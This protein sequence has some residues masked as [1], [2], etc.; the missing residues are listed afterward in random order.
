MEEINNSNPEE[1]S[2]PITTDYSIEARQKKQKA[3]IDL[4][5][6]GTYWK[7]AWHEPEKNATGIWDYYHIKRLEQHEGFSSLEGERIQFDETCLYHMDDRATLYESSFDKT[8]GGYY[9][10]Q[11]TKEE[12]ERMRQRVIDIYENKRR[13][14]YNRSALF[15]LFNN[16]KTRS[17]SYTEIMELTK[18][19]HEQVK[20][21]IED[22]TLALK[23]AETKEQIE[24]IQSIIERIKQNNMLKVFSMSEKNQYPNL[25]FHFDIHVIDTSSVS[26]K[27][28]YYN[29]NGV[30][31]VDGSPF[32][33]NGETFWYKVKVCC[34]SLYAENYNRHHYETD[35]RTYFDDGN[36]NWRNDDPEGWRD[37]MA[38]KDKYTNGNY[39]NSPVWPFDSD[40]KFYLLTDWHYEQLLDLIRFTGLENEKSL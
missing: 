37:Y 24:K 34:L 33:E 38:V 13:E 11:I 8:R 32:E 22:F 4:A 10:E 7:Q 25:S 29:D 17:F 31:Y 40:E 30:G 2:Q 5:P 3:L 36:K 26:F 6:L 18:N 9:A 12:Y 16:E 27:A 15:D 39:K 21:E 1:V 28:K 35:L 23:R 20:E 14:I 19:I